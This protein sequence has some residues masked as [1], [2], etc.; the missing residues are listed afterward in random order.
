[1][2]RQLMALLVASALFQSTTM[3]EDIPKELEGPVATELKKAKVKFESAT[4]KAGEK[5]LAAIVKERIAATTD[6][7]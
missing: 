1:M 3:A 7:I 4:E 5:L 6:F 2:V